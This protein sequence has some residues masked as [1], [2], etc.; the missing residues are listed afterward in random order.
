MQAPTILH[1]KACK[2]FLHYLK[3]TI[4]YGLHLQPSSH[5][6]LVAYS[7]A[8]WATDL[9][10]RHSVSGYYVFLGNSLISWSFHK[11]NVV[12][13]SSTESKFRALALV[14]SKL[15]WIHNLLTEIGF[16]LPYCP[17]IWCDNMGA[18]ALASNPIFHSHIKHLELNLHFL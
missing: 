10:D 4:N 11:Q 18:S 6:D 3:G 12:A 5:L 13:H 16:S 8:D 2:C 14:T 9:D 15:V 17:I 7:D 1:C